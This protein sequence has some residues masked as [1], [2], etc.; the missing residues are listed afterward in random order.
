MSKNTKNIGNQRHQTP[1]RAPATATDAKGKIMTL[2]K[3]KGVSVSESDVLRMITK[4]CFAAHRP[5]REQRGAAAVYGPM[6]MSDLKYFLTPRFLAWAQPLVKSK[7]VVVT[8]DELSNGMWTFEVWFSHEYLFRCQLQEWDLAARKEEKSSK[9][10]KIPTKT[11]MSIYLTGREKRALRRRA[12]R[13]GLR[14]ARNDGES[15]MLRLVASHVLAD[16]FKSLE[17]QKAPNPPPTKP[18]PKGESPK[19][20]SAYGQA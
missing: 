20:T 10:G 5:Y 3:Q 7:E 13:I 11:T 6:P 15:I 9:T 12:Q 4:R 18:A 8:L 2:L 14:R 1:F 19:P 16:C 17:S